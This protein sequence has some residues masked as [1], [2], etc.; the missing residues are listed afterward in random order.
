[1]LLRSAVPY[2][3]LSLL[4]L[5]PDQQ[6]R[7]FFFS[8]PVYS[9][10]YPSPAQP[11]L[12]LTGYFNAQVSGFRC[13]SPAPP[14]PFFDRLFWR[15]AIR[16]LVPLS[17]SAA[18]YSDRLFWRPAIRFPVPL[19]R[20]ASPFFDRLFWRPA[21]RFL[22]PLSRSAASYS[23]RLFWRPA[24][25]FPVP[26]SRSAASPSDRLFYRPAI[27]FSV[28]V[29]RSASSF[30]DRLFWRP[31][32]PFP[33]P[34][35]LLFAPRFGSLGRLFRRPPFSHPTFPSR[36][37]GWSARS[38]CRLTVS[39]RFLPLRGFLPPRGFY[40]STVFYRSAVFTAPPSP[41]FFG[42]SALPP[43]SCLLPPSLPPL[44]D[45]SL[46]VPPCGSTAIFTAPRFFPLR[47]FYRSAV[48]T[49]PRFLPLRFHRFFG[50]L[51][52]SA[53]L[54]LAA[55]QS[56]P[57]SGRL[58]LWATLRYA[59]D[60]YRS[61]VFTAPRFLPLRGFYRSAFTGSLGGFAL[62][63]PSS[64]LPPS[65]PP[66]PGGS[67]FVPPYGTPAVLPLR[68]FYRSAVFTA[69]RFLPLRDFYRSTVFTAPRFFPLR[70]RRF[71]GGLYSS[72]LPPRL[73]PLPGAPCAT[74]SSVAS[75]VGHHSWSSFCTTCLTALGALP[76][77]SPVSLLCISYTLGA[78]RSS[79]LLN[80]GTRAPR[81]LP[82]P[83]WDLSA[84][85]N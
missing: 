9:L 52:S 54:M 42:G 22:V 57:T 24:I 84:I 50:G 45:G 11:S 83:S 55:P 74:G 80:D 60:F 28:H 5:H 85:G 40:R 72:F 16:F 47:G 14:H 32:L 78:H 81:V 53:A 59:C 65:L 51:C 73:R 66:L 12:L 46:L 79:R 76:L 1:M 31:G 36:L 21:I 56:S 67:L 58:A 69:P 44:P 34:Q 70:F 48:F 33:V 38:L 13:L 30:S 3:S 82:P 15:P 64:L 19:S 71:F 18:S 35:G 37:F 61:V 43:P 77:I 26:L 25:R 49:A 4:L 62:P 17:R 8:L 27:R 7:L 6:V 41:V 63:L 39:L 10:V 2:H 20:S 75:P 23:D 68:G 29:S